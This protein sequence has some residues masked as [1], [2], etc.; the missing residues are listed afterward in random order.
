VLD[1]NVDASLANFD[2]TDQL[3]LQV[4]PLQMPVPGVSG[5]GFNV[6][7]TYNF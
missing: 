5:A 7:L 4:A 6:S 2:V 1:A 3:E